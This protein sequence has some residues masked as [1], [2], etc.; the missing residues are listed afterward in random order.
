MA[1]AA[2]DC[3][4]WA[5]AAA[6]ACAAYKAWTSASRACSRS[7]RALSLSWVSSFS[8]EQRDTGD[9]SNTKK[10]AT[11]AFIESLQIELTA[12]GFSRRR[13]NRCASRTYLVPASQM[14]D[15]VVL[16]RLG[17]LPKRDDSRFK[18]FPVLFRVNDHSV[19]DFQ[20]LDRGSRAALYELRLGRNCNGD[21]LGFF[22]GSLHR[23]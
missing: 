18:L 6:G 1:G 22:G 11:I 16:R 23:D 4:A 14:A 20:I 3:A 8:W 5:G 21:C 7:S 2:A 12:H 15:S 19:S 17:R 10:R 9:R 13:S